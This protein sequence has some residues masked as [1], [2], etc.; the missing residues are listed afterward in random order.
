[1]G[2]PLIIIGFALGLGFCFLIDRIIDWNTRR[3]AKKN[4][5]EDCKE[6]QYF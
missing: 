6:A 4:I 3:K 1:M 2:Y 5:D